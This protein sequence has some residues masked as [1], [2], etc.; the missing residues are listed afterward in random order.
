MTKIFYYIK[1]KFWLFIKNIT[2]HYFFK[3]LNLK[4]ISF[5]KLLKRKIFYQNCNFSKL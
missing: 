2:I 3:K 1:D 4:I 5:L